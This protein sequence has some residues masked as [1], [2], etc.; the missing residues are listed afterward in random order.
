MEGLF[1]WHW[2]GFVT[3]QKGYRELLNKVTP[4]FVIREYLLNFGLA[5]VG[6]A[7]GYFL[8]FKRG[9]FNDDPILLTAAFILFLLGATGYLPN[10]IVNKIGSLKG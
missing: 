1:P 8:F 3:K 6:W 9:I 7:T 5:L 2:H 4:L 10:F